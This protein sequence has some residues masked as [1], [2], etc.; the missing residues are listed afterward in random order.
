MRRISAPRSLPRPRVLKRMLPLF[1]GLAYA[2]PAYQDLKSSINDLSGFLIDFRAPAESA[3]DEA[4]SAFVSRIV[5]WETNRPLTR[6]GGPND[7]GYVMLDYFAFDHAI[8]IG[9]G[10]DVSWDFDLTKRGVQVSMFDPTVKCPPVQIPG[11][12][13][14]RK[15]LAAENSRWFATLDSLSSECGPPASKD[16]LLKCDVE[17]SEWDALSKVS[18]S[19]FSEVVIEFH[20]LSDLRN[21]VRAQE[22]LAVVRNLASTHFPVHVHAN[23]YSKLFRLDRYWFCD[24]IEVTWARRD[25]F[26]MIQVCTQVSHA[27]DAPCNPLASEISLEGIL[28]LA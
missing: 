19:R 22:M 9:V 28:A 17:G 10:R 27:A 12:R 3:A 15:G 11:A 16:L 13:F 1:D 24:V 18:F 20:D 25:S 14:Y 6:V 26:E 8:S 7:G 21:P 5:P 23:N 4:V 2:L